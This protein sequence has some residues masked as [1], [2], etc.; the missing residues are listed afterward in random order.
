MY[1]YIVDTFVQEKRFQRE[2]I[3]IQTRVQDLGI[4][5]RFE[6]LTILKSIKDIVHDAERKGVTTLVVIGSDKT[7]NTVVSHL[8]NDKITLGFIPVGENNRIANELSIPEGVS[9]CNVLSKRIVKKM[10]LGEVNGR[11]FFS[12]LDIPASEHV[13]IE[14]DKSY[15]VKVS[16]PQAIHIVNFGGHESPGNAFDGRLEAVVEQENTS[17]GFFLFSKKKHDR[18]SI[19]PIKTLTVKSDAETVPIFS[20][21]DVMVK[22]PARISVIPK[23]LRIITGA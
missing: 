18:N 22:T 20:E 19:F 8:T 12:S 17:R 2:L 15:Q 5:G 23:R 21:G 6:K 11:Y 16:H 10:D 4:S 14:C 9:A 3:T 1:L 7:F 13:T